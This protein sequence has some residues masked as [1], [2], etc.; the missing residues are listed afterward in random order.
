[1]R[2]QIQSLQHKLEESAK[3]NKIVKA[4]R[5]ELNV[6]L[7]QSRAEVDEY[8][9][10]YSKWESVQQ[11][12]DE[13]RKAI[14]D[15]EE[16]RDES[17]RALEAL[18]SVHEAS[19]R[20]SQKREAA[21]TTAYQAKMKSLGISTTQ[22]HAKMKRMKAE[23]VSLKKQLEGNDGHGQSELDKEN[24]TGPEMDVQ[25]GN[26]VEQRQKRNYDAAFPGP[27]GKHSSRT[28]YSLPHLIITPPDNAVDKQRHSP[29][30]RENID[31]HPL[32]D[33]SRHN[34]PRSRRIS[35]RPN[36]RHDVGPESP[37][38]PARIDVQVSKPNR[39]LA[40]E[41]QS[42]DEDQET[43]ETI[44]LDFDD[45]KDEPLGADERSTVP[46]NATTSRPLG[47]PKSEKKPLCAAKAR[48]DD[49]R[50]D[51]NGTTRMI[52]LHDKTN[53]VPLVSPD[54]ETASMNF[55]P[56][57][58][59]K[60]RADELQG[61]VMS[62]RRDR[63]AEDKQ[64]KSV[65]TATSTRN[66][67]RNEQVKIKREPSSSKNPPTSVKREAHAAKT[68]RDVKYETPLSS[69]VGSRSTTPA[70]GSTDKR[71]LLPIPGWKGGRSSRA[72][73]KRDSFED[74][75][76]LGFQASALPSTVKRMREVPMSSSKTGGDHDDSPLQA[77]K[78]TRPAKHGAIPA[79]MANEM[80]RSRTTDS[81]ALGVTNRSHSKG[82]GKA[83]VIHSDPVQEQSR[84]TPLG[85]RDRN[86]RRGSEASAGKNADVKM[87][88]PHGESGRMAGGRAEE[89]GGRAEEKGLDS[90]SAVG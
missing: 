73:A 51:V 32:S 36:L 16:E 55:A 20:D 13:A 86:L 35:K 29:V 71:K 64:G 54:T 28:C 83:D 47:I 7:E 2:Q 41:T 37:L 61:R 4:D 43:Q 30:T 6:C 75:D 72:L 38:R 5:D 82:G 85:D 31:R 23:I 40:K 33:N 52:N 90:H 22:D 68:E 8:R 81:P 19:L 74:D 76:G 80:A 3:E 63:A 62:N 66:S 87:S 15:A 46:R 9:E 88:G 24:M 59:Q 44:P 42:D 65:G 48:T 17:R 49:A 69:R 34:S 1:M 79:H 67:D 21:L 50:K 56:I 12:L 45:V 14:K 70:T 78:Y 77:K 25:E 39:I 84:M 53:F 89:K 27:D 11:E 18:Q 60:E 57:V 26:V 10:Y 58:P